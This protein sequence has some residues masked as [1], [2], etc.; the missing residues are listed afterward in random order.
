M[1]EE[2]RAKIDET[3]LAELD[4]LNEKIANGFKVS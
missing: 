1:S 3:I 4:A 2:D